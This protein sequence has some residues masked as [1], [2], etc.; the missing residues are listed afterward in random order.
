MLNILGSLAKNGWRE[1]FRILSSSE[2]TICKHPWSAR[3]KY[4]HVRRR[5]RKG[6]KMRAAAFEIVEGEDGDGAG[7]IY[8]RVKDGRE[9][10]DGEVHELVLE[11]K[12]ASSEDANGQRQRSSRKK[13]KEER[14]VVIEE[15]ESKVGYRCRMLP[16]LHPQLSCLS[17]WLNRFT[18]GSS[19]EQDSE[20]KTSAPATGT[21]RK[22]QCRSAATF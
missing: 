21:Q 4:A 19:A 7:R 1:T 20:A 22:F 6:R 9:M 2:N 17:G 3:K 11:K 10:D 18:G 14:D 8:R 5:D 15:R 12:M 13:E 16:V